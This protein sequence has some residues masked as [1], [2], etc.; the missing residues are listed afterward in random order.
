M[1]R[2]DHLLSQ[3]HHPCNAEIALCAWTHP[4]FGMCKERAPSVQEDL[5]AGLKRGHL[6]HLSHLRL[7]EVRLNNG[8]LRRNVWV[9]KLAAVVKSVVV[10]R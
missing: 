1:A 4:Q 6:L 10:C 7:K 5:D 8:Q 3:T 9:V 2:F